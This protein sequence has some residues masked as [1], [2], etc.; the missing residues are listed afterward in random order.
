MVN[1]K[2]RMRTVVVF[3][4]VMLLKCE[5][6]L[7]KAHTD[8]KKKSCLHI[9]PVFVRPFLKT[10]FFTVGVLYT[11][12]QHRQRQHKS[13]LDAA[14]VVNRGRRCLDKTQETVFVPEGKAILT[15]LNHPF[16]SLEWR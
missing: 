5:E 16:L 7:S 12:I 9:D 8:K 1:I 14:L 10:F 13:T 3:F 11:R 15:Q 6:M 2:P 4:Y